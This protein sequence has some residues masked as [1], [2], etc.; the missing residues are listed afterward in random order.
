MPLQQVLDREAILLG[1]TM[2]VS[3]R[4]IF[5]PPGW[6]FLAGYDTMKTTSKRRSCFY[7]I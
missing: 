4:M 6:I 5:M 1:V 3:K 7:G 2:W